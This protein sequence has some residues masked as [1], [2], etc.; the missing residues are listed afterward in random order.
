MSRRTHP[1]RVVCPIPPT[2][3]PWSQ[4]CTTCHRPHP[5]ATLTKPPPPAPTHVI[6]TVSWAY[7]FRSCRTPPRGSSAPPPA[8]TVVPI[9]RRTS[10]VHTPLKVALTASPRY[11]PPPG[12]SIPCTRSPLHPHLPQHL[13]VSQG[14]KIRNALQTPL[15]LCEYHATDNPMT[16][17]S[18][19]CV[20]TAN[21]KKS[22]A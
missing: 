3:S 17:D 5:T 19:A 7:P 8:P 12:L 9:P 20:K 1:A 11:R 15:L 14:I 16:T 18:P 6:R 4:L 13:P 10:Y 2:T 22:C 21:L